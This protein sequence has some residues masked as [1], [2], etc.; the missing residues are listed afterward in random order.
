MAVVGLAT[1]TLLT[2]SHVFSNINVSDVFAPIKGGLGFFSHKLFGPQVKTGEPATKAGII[3]FAAA[4]FA[5]IAG[6]VPQV[7]KILG[8]PFTKELAKYAASP[9]YRSHVNFLGTFQKDFARIV[10]SYV[11]KR[12]ASTCSWMIWIGVTCREP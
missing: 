2:A 11:G 10:Q 6:A 8:N 12:G 9:D 7:R 5:A 1:W 4:L 3:G